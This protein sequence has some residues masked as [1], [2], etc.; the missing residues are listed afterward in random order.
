MNIV[1]VIGLAALLASGLA[2]SA[3]AQTAPAPAA[4]LAPSA[5]DAILLTVF[6]KHDQAKTLGQINEDLRQHGYFDQ[7]PPQGVDVVSWYVVMGIGQ[8]VTL[9]VPP[10][11]LREVNRVL[12]DT[13][14]GAYRTEFFPSYDYKAAAEQQRREMQAKPK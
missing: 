5:S 1:K 14:W 13:A 7:F 8:I 10:A 11:K 4:A 12:E 6:L 2:G 9:R 3:S